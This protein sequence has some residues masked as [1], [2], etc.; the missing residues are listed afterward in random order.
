MKRQISNPEKE[1]PN[2]TPTVPEMVEVRAAEELSGAPAVSNDST[3]TPPVVKQE[4][5]KYA[6]STKE[7]G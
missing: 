3:V 2:P 4:E 5:G 7:K 1:Q 6:E